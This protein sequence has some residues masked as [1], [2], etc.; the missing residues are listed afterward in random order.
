MILK[1]LHLHGKKGMALLRM[2]DML[3]QKIKKESR[4]STKNNRKKPQKVLP[5]RLK[6]R[7]ILISPRI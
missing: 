3:T 7:S 6:L 4:M 2:S 5:Q 1:K